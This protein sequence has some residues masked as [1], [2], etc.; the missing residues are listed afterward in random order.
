MGLRACRETAWGH[1]SSRKQDKETKHTKTMNWENP[2]RKRRRSEGRAC[3]STPRGVSTYTPLLLRPSPPVI[4]WCLSNVALHELVSTPTLPLWPLAGWGDFA[5]SK[6]MFPIIHALR[7]GPG[8]WEVGPGY[9][10]WRSGSRP[11]KGQDRK[12]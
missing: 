3:P 8:Q 1:M 5:V 9:L 10:L 2:N 6:H 4:L 11:L 7:E 12:A